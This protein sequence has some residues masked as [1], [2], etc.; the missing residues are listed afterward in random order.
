MA[1]VKVAGTRANYIHE[2]RSH[3]AS[4]ATRESEIDELVASDLRRAE[5]FECLILL[6]SGST[7]EAAH[8][9]N[10]ALWKLVY[11]ARQ[12]QPFTDDEWH[13]Q[14]DKWITAMNNFHAAARNDLRVTGAFTRRDTAALAVFRPER[15]QQAQTHQSAT[16]SVRA[17]PSSVP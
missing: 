8:A 3:D 10:H 12:R 16:G 14:A 4:T 5:A 11:P 1:A 6:A 7:I 9:L 15:G 2:Q 17:D 13:E